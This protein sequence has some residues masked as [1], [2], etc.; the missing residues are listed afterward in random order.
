MALRA[1][2]PIRPQERGE[3]IN[4]F[5]AVFSVDA[6]F[7]RERA[8]KRMHARATRRKLVAGLK[9]AEPPL[10]VMKGG[11]SLL[12][13]KC[14]AEATRTDYAKRLHAFWEFSLKVGWVVTDVDSLDMALC[15]FADKL[16][17]EGAQVDA[18]SKL[19]AV[20]VHHWPRL[21]R[22][23]DMRLP[24]MLRVLKSWKRTFDDLILLDSKRYKLIGPALAR[25]AC[26]RQATATLFPFTVAQFKVAWQR[27]QTTLGIKEAFWVHQDLLEVQRRGGWKNLDMLLRYEKRGRIQ[28]S[29]AKLGDDTLDKCE[30][31]ARDLARLIR[32]AS[33]VRQ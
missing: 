5:E 4:Q 10:F 15:D 9:G 8:M 33:F 13:N 17:L 6:E 31:S 30:R 12:E 27:A 11:L 7:I 14:P 22:N 16:Y 2:R 20:V 32:V 19:M 23:G 29:L 21:G 28:K 24:R 1:S 26:T 18:G 3:V 25:L